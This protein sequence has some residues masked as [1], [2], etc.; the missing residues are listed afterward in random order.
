MLDRNLFMNKDWVSSEKLI[1]I[2]NLQFCSWSRTKNLLRRYW[3]EVLLSSIILVVTGVIDFLEQNYMMAGKYY[4][5][6]FCCCIN[7]SKVSIGNITDDNYELNLEAVFCTYCY[8]LVV[9]LSRMM[10]FSWLK[11][12]FYFK[13]TANKN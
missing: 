3:I 10:K 6:F 11:N 2:F 5:F 8:K 7:V 1:N 13:F 9:V 12:D 4:C